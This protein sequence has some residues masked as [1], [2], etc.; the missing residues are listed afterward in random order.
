[1]LDTVRI[2]LYE[3]GYLWSPAFDSTCS[4]WLSLAVVYAV[5]HAVV[6]VVK[7]VTCFV[8]SLVRCETAVS[9]TGKY[10]CE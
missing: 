6:G 5:S 9:A 7:G 3:K 1:M 8:I 10:L 2:V 4:T